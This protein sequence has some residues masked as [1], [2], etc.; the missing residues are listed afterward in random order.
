MLGI[1]KMPIKDIMVMAKQIII[2]SD[3][4]T[5]KVVP[6]TKIP[7]SFISDLKKLADQYAD[8][9]LVDGE[10][11][12]EQLRKEFK[13][14]DTTG[15]AVRAYR[16]RLDMTQKELSKRTKIAQGDLS[17]IEN[18]KLKP[19]VKVAKKLGKALKCDYKKFL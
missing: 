17:K 4:A 18:N 10:I 16:G 14:H 13:D 2:D 7:K 12:M 1:E 3:I 8:D 6:K 9:E 5:I 15:F 11:V 19:G